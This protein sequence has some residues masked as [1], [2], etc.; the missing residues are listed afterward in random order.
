[1]PRLAKQT[2]LP[3]TIDSVSPAAALPGGEVEL[4]GSHL[5]PR[6]TTA[7]VVLVDGSPADLLMS[8]ESRLAFKVP[9]RTLITSSGIIEVRTPDGVSNPINLRIARQLGDKSETEVRRIVTRLLMDRV[10][11]RNA[12]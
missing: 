12:A 9:E 2:L 3:P 10:R 8:R 7:P 6:G 11:D 1:M 5:G 4:H